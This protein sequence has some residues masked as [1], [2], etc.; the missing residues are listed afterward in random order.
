M[1]SKLLSTAETHSSDTSSS[2]K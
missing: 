1:R 2:Y